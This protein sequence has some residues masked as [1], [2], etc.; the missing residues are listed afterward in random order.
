MKELSVPSRVNILLPLQI[1]HDLL[2][3]VA[4]FKHAL[5]SADPHSSVLLQSALNLFTM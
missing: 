3:G 2:I 1:L 5:S 4:P